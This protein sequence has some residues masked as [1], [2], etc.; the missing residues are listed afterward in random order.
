MRSDVAAGLYVEACA[1]TAVPPTSE[2]ATA[3]SWLQNSESRSEM[4]SPPPLSAENRLSELDAPVF[5][6]CPTTNDCHTGLSSLQNAVNSAPQDGVLGQSN[7]NPV[8]VPWSNTQDV[9]DL[10]ALSTESFPEPANVE[11]EWFFNTGLTPFVDNLINPKTLAV[12]SYKPIANGAS[13]AP[14]PIAHKQS[15]IYLQERQSKMFVPQLGH[16]QAP[17]CGFS[18]CNTLTEEQRIELLIDL[19]SLL[20][21]DI[22]PFVARASPLNRPR[23]VGPH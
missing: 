19:R 13:V 12:Q 10:Q 22:R 15:R 8:T 23:T 18:I 3:S 9:D 2:T 1:H 6:S 5:T 16:V 17:L 20:D 11:I 4:R 7:S 14:A 21:I